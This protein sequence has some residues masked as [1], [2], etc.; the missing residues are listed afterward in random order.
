MASQVKAFR[1]K[2]GV[3]FFALLILAWGIYSIIILPIE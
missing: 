2:S 1:V 3:V